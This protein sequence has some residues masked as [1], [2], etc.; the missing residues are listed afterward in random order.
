MVITR[1]C[2]LCSCDMAI[3]CW[4]ASRSHLDDSKLLLVAYT[5]EKN[6]FSPD[7]SSISP[8]FFFCFYYFAN[9][10]SVFCCIACKQPTKPIARSMIIVVVVI[11]IVNS[12]PMLGWVFIL[13]YRN[14]TLHSQRLNITPENGPCKII[15]HPLY[16][17]HVAP[18]ANETKWN[19]I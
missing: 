19:E 5:N 18:I 2:T 6:S 3:M 4:F 7:F 8:M 10:V 15:V 13:M 17:I 1:S 16:T 12:T 14:K 9:K 11:G